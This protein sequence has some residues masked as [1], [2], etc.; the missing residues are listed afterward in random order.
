MPS[1]P[2]ESARAKI[3]RAKYHLGQLNDKI[4]ADGN[5]KKY[6]IRFRHES[7]TNQLVQNFSENP[8]PA[9]MCK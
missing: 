3:D 1:D 6:P 2:L 7:Q 4:Q 9:L 8:T 5:A